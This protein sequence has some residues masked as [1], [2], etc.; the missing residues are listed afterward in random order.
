M[1]KYGYL[2]LVMILWLISFSGIAAASQTQDREAVRSVQELNR[3]RKASSLPLFTPNKQLDE[4][5]MT[6]N[7]YMN[8][9]NV[10][11]S[12]EE[13]GKTY[14]RGRYPW[15]RAAFAGYEKAYVAELV[16]KQFNNYSEG[17]RTF[18]GDP[19]LRYNLLNPNYSEIGMDRYLDYSTYLLGGDL[20]EDSY[21]V[22][23]PHHQ[24][25]GIP[26]NNRYYFSKNPYEQAQKS[27]YQGYP[28]T[29][30]YYSD[31]KIERYEME[32]ISLVRLNTY[33]SVPLTYITNQLSNTIIILP[34]TDFE[35]FSSY[36]LK[37]RMRLVFADGRSHQVNHIS[38]FTTESASRNPIEE[39]RYLTRAEFVKKLVQT[40]RYDIKTHLG[41]VFKD[42][43]PA[44]ADSKYIYTAY[45]EKL[46][47]GNTNGEFLPNA[48]IR[49]QDVYVV[50]IRAYEKKRKIYLTAQ[51]Q[52]LFRQDI[53]SEYAVDPLRKAVKIGLIDETRRSF[54]PNHYLSVAEFN[55]ILKRFES[56]IK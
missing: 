36:E 8:Y 34:L 41:I 49:E 53:Q 40:L 35:Y 27:G 15:D 5:A 48:N 44:S 6:H 39:I 32:T 46:V 37:L 55:E 16:G 21:E 9:S 12:I 22:I 24:Q 19:Y 51:D 26:V 14:Y 33:Q 43:A 31:K 7:R 11:S 3:I 1:K 50:L 13:V 38:R 54:D 52:I 29:Y 56:I 28:L 42:V 2:F 47:E 4:A 20:V 17:W 18:L 23:Y 45:S 10:L 25:T 30:T